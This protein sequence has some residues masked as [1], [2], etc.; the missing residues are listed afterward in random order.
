[1]DQGS[2]LTRGLEL[3]GR[4]VDDVEAV[5]AAL[6]A[7]PH[8]LVAALG[9][10][11]RLVSMPDS[12]ALRGQRVFEGTSAIELVVEGDQ[13][14]VIDGWLRSRSDR[15]VCVSARFVTDPE[16]EGIVHFLD[17]RDRHGVWLIVL[18]ALEALEAERMLDAAQ[19]VIAAGP[20]VAHVKRDATSVLLEVDDAF[21]TNLGWSRDELIGR[22][23]LDLVHPEDRDRAI[24]AWFLMRRGADE[25]STRIRL[26]RADG[27]YVWLEIANTNH[28]D[29]PEDPFVLSQMVDISAE[30][31]ALE[32]LH[33]RERLLHRL[34]ETLPI[35]ICQLRADGQVVHANP[36]LIELLGPVDSSVTLLARIAEPDRVS[37][38]TALRLALQGRPSELVVGVVHGNEERRCELTFRTMAESGGIGGVVVCTSDVTDRELLRSELEYRAS[39]DELTGCLN[40]AATL[41]ALE[42]ALRDHRQVA[43]AY[44]DLDGFKSINDRLGHASGDEA[45]R[46]VAARLRSVIRGG[47][48]LG[49]MGG[50]EF[51]VICPQGAGLF[52]SEVLRSRLTDAIDGDMQFR[53]H[54]VPIRASI[55]VSVSLESEFETEMLLG[56]ADAAMYEVKG[57]RRS[58]RPGLRIVPHPLS[59]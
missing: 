18:G 16:Q 53:G 29:D 41:I 9:D 23:T 12:V 13:D 54:P 10:D 28:L 44:V 17:V 8:A 5:M 14:K 20:G 36:L 27:Q 32:A 22:P 37:V 51:V 21:T 6:L 40:R 43:V 1:M 42:R 30:M 15:V 39:H 19:T 3:P 50:D 11:G 35:G 47:D 26:R 2:D 49:R 25:A 48:R 4:G 45:L 24:D 34:A 31:A 55:G 52:D 57:Q 38:R 58:H 56:R 7:N 46:V 59:S 33:E